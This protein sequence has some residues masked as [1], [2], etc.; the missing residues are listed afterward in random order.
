M[1]YVSETMVWHY[2]NYFKASFKIVY[3]FIS[4][5]NTNTFYLIPVIHSEIFNIMI[6]INNKYSTDI[7]NINMSLLKQL[8]SE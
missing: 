6:Y 5:Y 8:N 7:Y 3:Y 4:S 1:Y 2:N